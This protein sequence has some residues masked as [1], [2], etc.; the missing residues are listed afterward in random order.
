LANFH[1]A[2][3]PKI[4]RGLSGCLLVAVPRLIEAPRR[5][6][7]SLPFWFFAFRFAPEMGTTRA[8][9]PAAL[10]ACYIPEV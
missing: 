7:A 1:F 8:P 3:T 9:H 10:Q 6:R 4:P 2:Q 5:R